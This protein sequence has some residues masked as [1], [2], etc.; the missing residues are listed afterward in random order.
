MLELGDDRLFD[1]LGKFVLYF[2]EFFADFQRREIHVRPWVKTQ[3][4]RGFPL[5]G[6]GQELL[7]VRYRGNGVLHQACDLGFHFGRRNTPADVDDDADLAKRGVGIQLH[8][9]LGQRDGAEYQH[10]A[11]EHQNRNGPFDRELGDAHEILR[12]APGII[13][14]FRNRPANS[15]V[16]IYKAGVTTRVKNVATRIPPMTVTAIGA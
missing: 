4:G 1:L 3:N 8:R 6:N 13:Y 7:Q 2:R 5:F 15:S 16:P 12:A 9:E 10:D 11:G 14:F